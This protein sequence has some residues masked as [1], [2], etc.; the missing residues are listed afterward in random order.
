ME[1]VEYLKVQY[2]SHSNSNRLQLFFTFL[3]FEKFDLHVRNHKF[4]KPTE[5]NKMFSPFKVSILN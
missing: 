2:Q 1:N 3:D 5:Q 4:A